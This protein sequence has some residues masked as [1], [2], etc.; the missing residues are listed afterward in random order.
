[1]LNQKMKHMKRKFVAI[2]FLTG[3]LFFG[4]CYPDGA[5]YVED[6][7]VVYSVYDKDTDFVSK[8]TYSLPDKIVK[9]TGDDEGDIEYVN[10]IYARP[11]LAQIDKNM[12]ALGWTK[13]T[14]DKADVQILP[15]AWT[16]TTVFYWGYWGDYWC[17]YY[18][19][20]CGGGG[21][22]YP[23]Y[24]TYSSVT[25]GTLLL[26]MVDPK[27]ENPVGGKKVVWT[28]ALNGLYQASYVASRVNGLIDQAF[29]QSPYLK[30]N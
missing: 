21:W 16:T 10:D 15:A 5:D 9:I 2:V 4:G 26:T 11:T 6:L 19:Y 28:A 18:P 24:P 25:T 7:D 14:A 12:Q 29:T 3:I 13:T 17:W 1:M 27:V 8:G 20:Y 30:T 22:Y 23:Y